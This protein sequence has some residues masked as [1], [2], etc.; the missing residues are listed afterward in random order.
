MKDNT[1]VGFSVHKCVMETW[2]VQCNKD[3]KHIGIQSPCVSK[4]I[5]ITIRCNGTR[6]PAAVV[7]RI[8]TSRS[9]GVRCKRED[10]K[11]ICGSTQ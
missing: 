2:H 3:S 1:N 9:V 5:L 6:P 4:N 7:G 10:V 8:P 11:L